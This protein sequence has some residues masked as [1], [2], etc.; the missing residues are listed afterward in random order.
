M[1]TN[2]DRTAVQSCA[3]W[4]CRAVYPENHMDLTARIWPDADDRVVVSVPRAVQPPTALAAEMNRRFGFDRAQ[5]TAQ[6]GGLGRSVVVTRTP[7][8]S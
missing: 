5:Y 6:V 2:F 8:Y 4:S 7:C 3:N 1:M